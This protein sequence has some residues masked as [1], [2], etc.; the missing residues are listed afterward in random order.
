MSSIV[1]GSFLS[2]GIMSF[3]SEIAVVANNL[4]FPK[5][6]LFK[7]KFL[8]YRYI[9]KNKSIVIFITIWRNTFAEDLLLIILC[10]LNPD[11]ERICMIELINQL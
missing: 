8:Y 3:D 4:V 11:Y 1:N 7:N 10:I 2:S 5:S 6:F 9:L